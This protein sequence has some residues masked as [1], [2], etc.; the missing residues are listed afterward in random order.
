MK[1]RAWQLTL[2]VLLIMLATVVAAGV[3]YA[4]GGD[5]VFVTSPAAN[6]AVSGI[7]TITGAVDFPD[8]MKYD[9]FLKRGDEMVWAATVYAPVINGVL[10]RLDTRTFP[11][12]AYQLVIRQVHSDSNYTDFYGPTFFI[13]NNLGAPLPFPEVEPG[14]LYPPVAGALARIRN[15]SGVDLKFDYHSP[16]SF[17]SGGSLT[18][19]PKPAESQVCPFTDVLLIPCEYQGTAM[20]LGVERGGS[21]NFVAEH[22][23]IYELTYSG[24]DRLYVAEVPGDTRAATDTALLP[25]DDPARLAPVQA[26]ADAPAGASAAEQSPAEST[27]SE[28]AKAESPASSISD[29]PAEQSPTEPPTTETMLPVSGEAAPII[30][31]YLL[32]GG[33]VV[34][35]LVLAG[36]YAARRQAADL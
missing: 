30:I 24:E 6:E 35:L 13:E 19:R 31:P 27:G 20:G 1:N 15:C 18:V 12:G 2:A 28:T 33:G 29:Q 5:T 9:L 21:Y 4:Q 32:I 26:S 22:G 17:C 25:A 14:V 8:F 23:K 36:L 3:S 34:L 10:A 7:I 11:D 16:D